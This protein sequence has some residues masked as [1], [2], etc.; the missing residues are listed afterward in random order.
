MQLIQ[1]K[2]KKQCH[3]WACKKWKKQKMQSH[4]WVYK[5]QLIQEKQMQSHKWEYKKMEEA[6]DAQ[7]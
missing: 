6:E 3:E 5:M 2:Q 7:S 4:E 1:D